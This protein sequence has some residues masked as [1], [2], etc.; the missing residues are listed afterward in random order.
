[1]GVNLSRKELLD[2]EVYVLNT[3]SFDV[4][5]LTP[6]EFLKDSSEKEAVV[7]GSLARSLSFLPPS[8]HPAEVAGFIK[9]ICKDVIIPY[10]YG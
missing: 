7:H 1:L 5:P 9:S 8:I 10:L 6:L 4:I 2:A 3:V